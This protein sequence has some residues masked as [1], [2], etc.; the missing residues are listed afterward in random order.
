MTLI[1]VWGKCKKD[2]KNCISNLSDCSWVGGK[3]KHIKKR[4]KQIG[5][6]VICYRHLFQR[7]QTI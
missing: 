2:L 6:K 1:N 7:L 5:V 4:L 3:K